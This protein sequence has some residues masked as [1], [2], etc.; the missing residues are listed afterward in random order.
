[1]SIPSDY[2]ANF[3]NVDSGGYTHPPDT[4][5]TPSTECML[6]PVV[7]SSRVAFTPSSR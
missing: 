7:S 2:W 4:Y 3:V 6:T 5:L 1:M